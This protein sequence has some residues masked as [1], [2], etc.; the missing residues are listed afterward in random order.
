M[1]VEVIANAFYDFVPNAN[2]RMLPSAAEPQVAMVHEEVD[3]VLFGSDRIRMLFGHALD[4]YRVR[5]IKLIAARGPR[6]SA[7]CSGD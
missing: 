4:H 2:G 5:D 3:A 1:R 6:F 7:H